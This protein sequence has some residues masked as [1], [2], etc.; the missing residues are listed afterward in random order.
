MSVAWGR[1]AACCVAIVLLGAS[2]AAL[3]QPNCTQFNGTTD[4]VPPGGLQK[5]RIVLLVSGDRL[6]LILTGATGEMFVNNNPSGTSFTA[7]TNGNHTVGVVAD[8]TNPPTPGTATFEC[9]PAPVT[10]PNPNPPNP[11]TPTDPDRVRRDHWNAVLGD[12]HRQGLWSVVGDQSQ[13]VHEA[14][15]HELLRPYVVK[16]L[17]GGV[18]YQFLQV[19]T[20]PGSGTGPNP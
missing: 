2:G 17:T 13:A 16:E 15:A 12:R 1:A 14:G 5:D 9:T 3:A 18:E 4:S 7:T 11:P 6:R 8:P 10:P 20:V 19:R